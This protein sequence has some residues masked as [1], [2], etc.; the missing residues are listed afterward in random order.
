MSWAGEQARK[1]LVSSIGRDT[2]E[3]TTRAVTK[4]RYHGVDH[5]DVRS[6]HVLWNPEV[7]KVMLVD[8]ERSKI[9]KQMPVLQQISPD[10]KRKHFIFYDELCLKF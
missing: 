7:G 10:R 5:C 4:L 9:L 1:D 2:D 8:L 6:P 3:E